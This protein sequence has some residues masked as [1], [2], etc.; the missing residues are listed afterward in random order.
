QWNL[1][2]PSDPDVNDL[3]APR[4]NP[5]REVEF[6]AISPILG[7]V[8]RYGNRRIVFSAIA[9]L[10]FQKMLPDLA[11]RGGISAI[12]TV[13]FGFEDF[14]LV[15][16][17]DRGWFLDRKDLDPALEQKLVKRDSEGFILREKDSMLCQ[18]DKRCYFFVWEK[19]GCVE[20]D[21]Q[22]LTDECN[23]AIREQ[24]AGLGGNP[25]QVQIME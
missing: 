1:A 16:F 12:K 7:F 25:A 15:T 3:L 19:G 4:L 21:F 22:V 17:E 18:W 20:Y 11:T 5:V 6:L 8:V 13:S 14:I 2:P 10:Y 24:E 9:S 23:N